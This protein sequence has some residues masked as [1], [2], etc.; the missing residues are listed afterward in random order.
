MSKGDW[1]GKHKI[2]AISISNGQNAFSTK[3]LMT[4]L[5]RLSKDI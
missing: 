1:N 5:Y 4:G 3:W 2:G